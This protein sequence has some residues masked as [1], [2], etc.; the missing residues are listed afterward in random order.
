MK[1]SLRAASTACRAHVRDAEAAVARRIGA[2][3]EALG[4]RTVAAGESH[5][6]CLRPADGAALSWGAGESMHDDDGDTAYTDLPGLHLLGQG[7]GRGPAVRVPAPMVGL[8]G[9][10]LRLFPG[11]R[12]GVP[13]LVA[14]ARFGHLPTVP[15]SFHARLVMEL[16]YIGLREPVEVWSDADLDLQRVRYWDGLNEFHLNPKGPGCETVPVSYDGET[17]EETF[18]GLPPWPLQEWFPDTR[19]FTAARAHRNSS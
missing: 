13:D 8:G 12:S 18:V 1:N 9:V 4:P 17:G 19:L 15:K 10:A 11:P 2:L 7:Q 3:I 6:L 5:L 14:A 16:P